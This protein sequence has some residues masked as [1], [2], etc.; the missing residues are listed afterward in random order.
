MSSTRAL[1]TFPEDQYKLLGDISETTGTPIAELV[2]RA[3]SEKFEDP[4]SQKQ[5]RLEL[6]KEGSGLWA[7]QKE[8]SPSYKQLRSQWPISGNR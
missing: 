8:E 2:R 4:K 7:D 1:I 5:A 6:L 3:V